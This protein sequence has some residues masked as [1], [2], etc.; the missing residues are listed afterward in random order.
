M[1][2]DRTNFHRRALLRPLL[3]SQ[4]RAPLGTIGKWKACPFH[5]RAAASRKIAAMPK[6]A[7]QESH[8]SHFEPLAPPRSAEPAAPASESRAT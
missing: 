4:A 5:A 7:I 2:R 1:P 3:K 6:V 8:S